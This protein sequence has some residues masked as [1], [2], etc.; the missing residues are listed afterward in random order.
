MVNTP[1]GTVEFKLSL[2]DDAA[3]LGRLHGWLRRHP[4]TRRMP[5]S[6]ARQDTASGAMGTFD[7]IVAVIG[8]GIDLTAL[9][10]A[11]AAW[12]QS[13]GPAAPTLT[14]ERDGTTITVTGATAEQIE[15]QLRALTDG[16][17]QAE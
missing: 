17:D 5:L 15:A 14:V 6:V 1:G 7:V 4:D 3:A 10:V 13:A 11:I 12:R 9:A 2:D 8:V 16:E